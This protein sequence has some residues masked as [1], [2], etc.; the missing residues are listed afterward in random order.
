MQKRIDKG[1]LK[2]ITQKTKSSTIGKILKDY[3]GMSLN[4][5]QNMSRS[6]GNRG[7]VYYMLTYDIKSPEYH[8]L[9][10]GMYGN[11]KV[12]YLSIFQGVD[13]D[14]FEKNLRRHVSFENL[15]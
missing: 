11:F 10:C 4:S 12:L 6:D 7:E 3:C 1:D 2:K 13:M 9:L 5:F 8:N 15:T 14:V